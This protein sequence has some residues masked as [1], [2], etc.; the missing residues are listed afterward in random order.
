[1]RKELRMTFQ[2]MC[3]LYIYSSVGRNERKRSDIAV[4]AAAIYISNYVK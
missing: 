3:D 2:I 1:M 4:I